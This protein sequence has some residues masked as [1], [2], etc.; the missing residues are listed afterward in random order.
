MGFKKLNNSNLILLSAKNNKNIIN[1]IK[2]NDILSFFNKKLKVY[3]IVKTI[4][5][6]NNKSFL[7]SDLSYI[8]DKEKKNILSTDSITIQ[9]INSHNS[10]LDSL[11]FNLI[12]NNEK[13]AELRV[14]DEKRRKIKTNDIWIFTK[15]DDKDEKIIVKVKQIR[16]YSSFEE[17]I[18][19]DK[20][21]YLMPNIESKDERVSIYE[22]FPNYKE[23]GQEFGV[24]RFDFE[25]LNEY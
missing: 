6:P 12:R 9:K 20:E 13:K 1:K 16:I 17:A 2:I 25:L 3:Y 19:D 14:Y 8:M 11:Y 7:F 24:V 4:N 10:N 22:S 15:K 18:Y 5:K 21:N 23:N